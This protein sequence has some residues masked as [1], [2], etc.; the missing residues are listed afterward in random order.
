[1]IAILGATGYTGALV[2]AS[3][4]REMKHAPYLLA[5]RS[6]GRLDDV[7]ARAGTPDDVPAVVADVRD[8]AS[9]RALVARCSVVVNCV[10]PFA[11]HGLDVIAACV[12][13]GR[14]YIDITGEPG[15]LS[16]A[17]ERFDEPARRK[18]LRIVLSA[19]F[20]SVPT[21]CAVLC[22]D[23]RLDLRSAR[24]LHGAVHVSGPGSLSSGSLRG[25]SDGTCATLVSSF[26]RFSRSRIVRA[27]PA[28]LLVRRGAS[29]RWLLRT[30]T[31]DAHVVRRTQELLGRAGLSYAHFVEFDSLPRLA[32]FV[33]A[34]GGLMLSS[35]LPWLRRKW[36]AAGRHGRGPSDAA[37]RASAFD[38][39]VRGHDAGG[40]RATARMR[41]PEP[42]ET[43]AACV[44]EIARLVAFEPAALPPQ[45]GVCTPGVLG[46]RT[47]LDR[48]ARH[49]IT[50]S[51]TSE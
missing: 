32:R 45:A 7:R 15:F 36:A 26:A 42:Y 50:L 13:L 9:L 41:G 33:V 10:G 40:R 47:I 21:D 2:V 46:A 28:P 12:E 39:V 44:T 14:H 4:A 25:L 35:R 3:F 20:D 49:G 31:I 16:R 17:V 43:T 5:A 24:A 1:V 51:V 27:G 38:L 30:P 11:E 8:R 18:S 22:C 19:G 6:P 23:E 34:V 29:G 48:V 37:R